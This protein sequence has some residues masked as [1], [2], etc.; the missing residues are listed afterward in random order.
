MVVENPA[1]QEEITAVIADAVEG[2][3]HKRTFGK[4]INYSLPFDESSNFASGYTA[5]SVLFRYGLA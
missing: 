2:G 3:S 1:K 5:Y 4:E